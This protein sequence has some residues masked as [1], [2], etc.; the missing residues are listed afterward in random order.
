MDNQLKLFEDR[1]YLVTYWAH[2]FNKQL[3]Y[4]KSILTKY[5]EQIPEHK[6]N[7]FIKYLELLKYKNIQVKEI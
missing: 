3:N 1:M 7:E 4:I 5:E 6:L 2:P